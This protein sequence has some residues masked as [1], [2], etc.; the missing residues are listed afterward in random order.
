MGDSAITSKATYGL[1]NSLFSKPE[2]PSNGYESDLDVPLIVERMRS[3]SVDAD[4]NIDALISKMQ[5]FG[6]KHT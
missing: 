3:M 1:S 5:A 4:D 2:P 6:V